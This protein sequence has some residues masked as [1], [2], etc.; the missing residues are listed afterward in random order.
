MKGKGVSMNEVF[1][2]ILMCVFLIIEAATFGIITI[3]FAGGALLALLTALIGF[4]APIQIIVFVVSSIAL[5]AFTRPFVKKYLQKNIV[6]TNVDELIGKVA[7]VIADIDN[8]SETGKVFVNGNE[9]TARS[10]DGKFIEKETIVQI[11]KVE[12]VKLIVK[13]TE[14]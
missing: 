1:W 3:W 14:E 8:I 12:G 2:L 7:K 5:L 13:K 6:K 10:D 9:W 11:I 4:D